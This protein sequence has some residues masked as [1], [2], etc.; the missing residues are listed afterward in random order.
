MSYLWRDFARNVSTAAPASRSI[1]AMPYAFARPWARRDVLVTGA[2]LATAA[3]VTSLP[4]HHA[5]SATSTGSADGA[6]QFVT[7]SANRAIAVM[8]DKSLS[9]KDRI[10]KFHDLFIASFDLPAIGEHVL[11]RYW[12]S[13]SPDQRSKFLQLFEEQEVLTWSA[14]FKTY[15]GE[16]LVVQSADADDGNV[17]KVESTIT[18]PSGGP[19]QLEWTVAQ[20][21]AN[22]HITDIAVGGA[23]MALTMRQDFGSVISSHGGKID[24]LLTAMQKKI[25]QLRNA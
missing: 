6:K 15:N 17:W 5:L 13:A 16:K 21:G 3:A 19:V 8:A 25:D 9:D 14:R 20:T 1:H 2:T 7:D 23:S 24:A 10:A 4:L 18:R 11:G 12:N 22:W